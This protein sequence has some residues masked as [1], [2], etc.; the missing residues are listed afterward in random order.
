MTELNQLQ[1][2]YRAKLMDQAEKDGFSLQEVG[3]MFGVSK[4]RVYQIINNYRAKQQEK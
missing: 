4:A 3:D 1:L 2:D